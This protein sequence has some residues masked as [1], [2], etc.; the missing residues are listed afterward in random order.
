MGTPW[1]PP[2][3]GGG[4]N[5]PGRT[6]CPGLPPLA[7]GPLPALR[8]RRL[9]GRWSAF[10]VLMAEASSLMLLLIFDNLLQA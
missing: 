4:R 10:A 3:L 5:T 7:R 9:D 6:G 2:G 1:G 8:L